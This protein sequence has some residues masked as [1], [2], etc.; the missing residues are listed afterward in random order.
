M[1]TMIVIMSQRRLDSPEKEN[2]KEDGRDHQKLARPVE[3]NIFHE[4]KNR[5]IDGSA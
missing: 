5:A 1:I 2:G 4:F 3:Y